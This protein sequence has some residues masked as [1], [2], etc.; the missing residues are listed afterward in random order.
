M[1]NN[2]F[3]PTQARM[4]AVLADGRPHTRKELHACLE[5]DLAALAAIK[6]HIKKLRKKLKPERKGI[7]CICEGWVYSYQLVGILSTCDDSS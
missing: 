1:P 4:L 3:T 5:D 6:W 2:G 7:V